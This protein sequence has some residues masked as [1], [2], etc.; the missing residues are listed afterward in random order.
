MGWV[1]WRA[2]GV[3]VLIVVVGVGMHVVSAILPDAGMAP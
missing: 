3:V 1:M 2:V